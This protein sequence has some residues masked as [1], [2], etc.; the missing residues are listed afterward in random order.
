[1][2][3]H[4][5]NCRAN[6]P[7]FKRL[8]AGFYA[9]RLLNGMWLYVFRKDGSWHW[10]RRF[11]LYPTFELLNPGASDFKWRRGFPTRAMAISAFEGN[12]VE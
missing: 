4:T 9:K 6:S 8:A 7:G 11:N 10:T 2:T 1:M 5:T 12:R 3:T